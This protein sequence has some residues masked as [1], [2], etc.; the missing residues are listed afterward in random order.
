M[1][2]PIYRK[3]AGGLA[4]FEVLSK[5]EFRELKI[6]GRYFEVHHIRAKILPERVYIGDL[7]NNQSGNYV[8]S[9]RE[10]FYRELKACEMQRIR[11]S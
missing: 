6:I 1:N 11:L 8:N 10:E 4:F 2:F 7:I 5:E 3:Y 9:D